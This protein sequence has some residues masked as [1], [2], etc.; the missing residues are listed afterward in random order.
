MASSGECTQVVRFT[1]IT[2]LVSEKSG[3]KWIEL[4]DFMVFSVERFDR[5]MFN[6]QCASQDG[7]PHL[8]HT[9]HRA[10]DCG[11]TGYIRESGNY[12]LDCDA[13]LCVQLDPTLLSRITLGPH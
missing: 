6:V 3:L 8:N 2:Y 9:F 4:V 13:E 12:I 10:V 5:W 7:R 1:N 11:L